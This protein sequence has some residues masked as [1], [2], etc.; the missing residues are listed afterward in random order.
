MRVELERRMSSFEMDEMDVKGSLSLV[1][2]NHSYLPNPKDRQFKDGQVDITG[3]SSH[4]R[5]R[6]DWTVRIQR[7]LRYIY[8][9]LRALRPYMTKDHDPPEDLPEN[10]GGPLLPI[11]PPIEGNPL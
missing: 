6:S 7:P 11:P 3:S 5:T 9:S 2:G 4:E 10:P 8:A 1:L